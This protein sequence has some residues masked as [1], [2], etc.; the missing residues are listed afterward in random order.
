MPQYTISNFGGINTKLNPF[1]QPEGTLF[2]CVNLESDFIGVKSKRGGLVPFLNNPDSA[3]IANIIEFN[4]GTLHFLYRMSGTVCYYYDVN[5]PGTAW[6]PTTNGTFP[7]GG[8]L[9][10]TILYDTLICGN[11]VG[12]TRHTQN[13]TAFTNTNLAP[14]ARFFTNSFGR[15]YAGNNQTLFWSSANDATNWQTSGTS[16]SSSIQIPG[17]G[18]VN[19]LF[20]T[21]NRVLAG[22]SGGEMN[23]WDSYTRERVPGQLGPTS[24]W[25]NVDMDDMKLYANRLGVYAFTGVYP[26]IISTPVEK[27]FYNRANSGIPGTSFPD[28]PAG[29]SQ[30]NYYLSQGT[31]TDPTTNHTIPNSVLGY[32]YL[33]NEFYNL[34]F[35]FLPS[36]YGKYTDASGTA[37]FLIGDPSGQIYL[38]DS[39]ATS[40]NGTA[41]EGYMEGFTA[42]NEIYKD[43]EVYR[44]WVHTNPGCQAKLQ[45]S[46]TDNFFENSRRWID[47]GDLSR[48]ITYIELPVSTTRRGKYLFYRF[49]ES[50]TDAPWTIYAMTFD[51]NYVGD[52]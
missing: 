2:S 46:L 51:F 42:F 33:E 47:V 41:I 28:L 19:S 17:P 35:P 37:N 22:K 45:V 21:Y 30:Y 52:K 8:R 9:G 34:S 29:E 6:T 5:N 20:S 31:I 32:S 48:G 25:S 11:S 44:M 15:V 40:D 36:A 12:S 27:Q 3:A 49:Y 10:N 1:L 18:T 38:Y 4:V 50:S 23:R 43:K 24:Q 16:D 13:G 14:L 7:G 39:T 26:K